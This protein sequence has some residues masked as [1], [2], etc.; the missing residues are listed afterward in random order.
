MPPAIL[1][2]FLLVLTRVG[3]FFAFL[4]LPGGKDAPDAPRIVLSVGFTLALFPE[5]PTLS[6]NRGWAGYSRP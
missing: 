1:F 6:G 4:P 3:G 5:W 2:S